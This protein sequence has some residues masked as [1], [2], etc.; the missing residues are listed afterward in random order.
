MRYQIGTITNLGKKRSTNQDNFLVRTDRYGGMPCAL[1]LVADGMG[2]LTNGD[3]ASGL[4]VEEM[5]K[6]WDA[7]QQAHTAS[8]EISRSLDEVIYKIH[9]EIYAYEQQMDTRTGTTLSLVFLQGSRYLVKHVGDSRIYRLRG[10]KM[11]QITEDHSLVGEFVRAGLI[12]KEEARVHPRRNIITRAL[13]TEGD[14]TPDLLAADHLPGDRFLLCTDG[15]TGM[16]PD[17]EIERVL[18][19]NDIEAAADKLIAM[20]LDAGG[21]DNV[22][23]IL[24]TGEEGGTWKQD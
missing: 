2:G 11:E 9:R 13:G 22:T 24:C 6:W 10:G 7:R 16:V 8:E 5:Q 1:L 19:E 18:L 15:L 23:L 14:N 20:A 12:T 17:E 3:M 21:S 4:V